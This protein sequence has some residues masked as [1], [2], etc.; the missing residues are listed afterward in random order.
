MPACLERE[1]CG[2][3]ANAESESDHDGAGEQWALPDHAACEAQVLQQII[4]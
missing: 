2:T 3:E 4:D 1:G